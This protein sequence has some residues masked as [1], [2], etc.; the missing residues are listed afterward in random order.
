M[1]DKI[2]IKQQPVLLITAAG[3]G[4]RMGKEVPKLYLPLAGK[5]VLAHTL[6]A[7][8]GLDLFSSILIVIAPDGKK[9]FDEQIRIPFFPEE[10]RF[11][12]IEGGE[13]RQYSVFNA[14]KYLHAKKP[15]QDFV[16]CIHDGARPLVDSSLILSVYKEALSRGAAVPG[17]PLQDTIKEIDNNMEVR[18]TPPR[19]NYMAIQTPQCFLFSLLWRAHLRAKEENFCGSDDSMLLERLGIGVKVVP[20]NFANLKLTT[21]FDLEIARAYLAGRRKNG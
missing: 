18:S 21:P 10:N 20:G 1:N 5:P 12:L 16:V 13:E 17:I 7:F 9:L 19:E 2:K 15:V 4:S 11:F 8:L 6:T 14:L 3:R